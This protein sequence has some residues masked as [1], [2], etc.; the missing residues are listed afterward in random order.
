[1]IPISFESKLRDLV[2]IELVSLSSSPPALPSLLPFPFPLDSCNQSQHPRLAF[3]G[4]EY[5]RCDALVAT[6]LP[7][8]MMMGEIA[9][10]YTLTQIQLDVSSHPW[11]ISVAS[12]PHLPCSWKTR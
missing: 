4:V 7:Y 3:G 12:P 9:L 5:A 6:V 2:E 8:V 11:L 1:M 10:L